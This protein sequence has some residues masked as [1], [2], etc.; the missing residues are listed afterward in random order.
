MR[1]A[2]T[3]E[4][5]ARVDLT[6]ANE[7]LQGA[8]PQEIL[9][10]AVEAFYPR[11]TMATAF[12]PEG[13]VILHMLAEIEPRVRVFN[14]ETGYQFA[15]T[16]ALRD[17]IAERYGI[18]VEL[19]RPETTVAE[20][21][22]EHGGPLYVAHPD[23]CCHDRKL[24]PL[25]RAV[26]GYEAWISAIRADQSAHRARADVVGWDA[27]FGLVKVNPLLRWTKRDVWAF[28]VTN[29]VPYNPLHDQ[30]YASIG[31][32]PCTQAIAPGQDERA[33]RW[34]GQ[35]KTECGLHSLDSSQL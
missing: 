12:G 32:W 7:R 4:M 10:W 18:E 34:A 33:G 28:A 2:M 6:E 30:G 13:C 21:E 15:E 14:L 19:V 29:K 1:I 5:M 20:Y 8:S 35:A 22:A 16:L 27:K 23:R 9:R 11:L 31:C 3:A 25:R 17:Q 26:A 24:V